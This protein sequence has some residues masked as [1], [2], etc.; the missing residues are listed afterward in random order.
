MPQKGPV[1]DCWE[2]YQLKN[3]ELLNKIGADDEPLSARLAS[4]PTHV[5]KTAITYE[6][7]R[8]VHAGRAQVKELTLAALEPAIEYVNEH[9]RAG[10]FLSRYAERKAAQ[11]QAELYWRAF[12]KASRR[13]D[14]TPFM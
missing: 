6:T 9:L 3:R 13:N 1:W 5:L 2:A 7:C 8:A 14:P 4:C 10:E 12:A 11:E